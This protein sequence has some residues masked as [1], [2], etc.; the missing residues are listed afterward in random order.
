MVGFVDASSRGIWKQPA[1]PRGGESSA[2]QFPIRGWKLLE[3][4]HLELLPPLGEVLLHATH[5]RIEVIVAGRRS[6]HPMPV[7]DV[8][9][10]SGGPGGERGL[11]QMTLP[12]L[13]TTV[14][15]PSLIV[16]YKYEFIVDNTH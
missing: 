9:A 13:D 12:L 5:V 14:G 7:L 6:R 8:G 3:S 4:W 2:R 15:V 1:S 11:S 10:E 16:N